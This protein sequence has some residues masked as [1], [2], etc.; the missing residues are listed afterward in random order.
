MKKKAEKKYLKK[1]FKRLII[2][3]LSFLKTEKAEDLHAMRVEIKKMKAMLTM[4]EKITSKHKTSKNFRPITKVFKLAGQ[5]R[6]SHINLEIGKHYHIRNHMFLDYQNQLLNESVEELKSNVFKYIKKVKHAR[7]NVIK[8]HVAYVKG[9]ELIK[10]YDDE[11]RQISQAIKNVA[12]SEELHECRKRIKTLVY[13]YKFAQKTTGNGL[14][15]NLQYLDSV[16]TQIGDWHDKILDIE[17][18]KPLGEGEKD[19]INEMKKENIVQEKNL[20]NLNKDFFYKT[21]LV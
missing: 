17:L 1:R 11:I 2:H 18:F 9:R 14:K 8:H 7:K 10:F 19:V 6:E 21:N 15:L 3:L 20:V 4:L 12:F 16:Q 13:N 5:I